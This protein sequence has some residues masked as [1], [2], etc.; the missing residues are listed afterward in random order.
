[1]GSIAEQYA[2]LASMRHV[3]RRDAYAFQNSSSGSTYRAN[4]GTARDRHLSP[5]ASDA[6]ECFV[7][8]CHICRVFSDVGVLN[9]AVFVDGK[10]SVRLPSARSL[11]VPTHSLFVKR[12]PSSPRQTVSDALLLEFAQ[13]RQD[14]SIDDACYANFAQPVCCIHVSLRVAVA[15]YISWQG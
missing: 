5:S 13:L 2:G 4:E 6:C 7:K 1:M 3:N 8:V 9:L 15:L 10:P 11:L 14:I 12:A